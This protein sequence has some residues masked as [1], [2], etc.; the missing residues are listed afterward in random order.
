MHQG[1]F[2]FSPAQDLIN[3]SH[4]DQVFQIIYSEVFKLALQNELG[5]SD[6]LRISS[7]L[8]VSVHTVSQF[9]DLILSRTFFK[10]S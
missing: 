1:L 3:S 7:A 9:P 2:F 5:R 6:P 8:T 10:Q 4:Q